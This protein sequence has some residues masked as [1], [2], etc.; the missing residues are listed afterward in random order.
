MNTPLARFD[1]GYD[2]RN[3]RTSET[4]TSGG[5]PEVRSFGYDAADRLTG[6]NEVG[7]GA[8][9]YG[10]APDGTRL[11]ERTVTGD[12]GGPL[13][14]GGCEG[15]DGFTSSSRITYQHDTSGELLGASDAVTGESWSYLT[16]PVG[17]LRSQTRGGVSRSYRWDAAGR[18]ASASVTTMVAG[19]GGTSDTFTYGYDHAGRRVSKTWPSGRVS[20][21]WGPDGVVEEQAGGTAGMVYE[22]VGALALGAGGERIMHDGLGSV[23]GRVGAGVTSYR[24]DVSGAYRGAAPGYGE[25]SLRYAGQHWDAEAGLSYA[26]QRWY[27]PGTGR[28]LS[29]DPVF[30]HQELPTSLH[31][32]IYANGNA[33]TL[34]DSDGRAAT[35][36]FAVGGFFWGFEQMVQGMAVD[37]YRGRYRSSGAYL[38]VWGQNII[39][40]TELG[41]SID[42]TA[43][44]GG[45][46]L[47]VSGALGWAGT[48]A[49]T[50]H[51]RAKDWSTFRGNQGWGLLKGAV[52]GPIFHKVAK[53]LPWVGRL[54]RRVPGAQA[55]EQRLGNALEAGAA[56]VKPAVQAIGRAGEGLYEQMEMDALFGA[57]NPLRAVSAPRPQAL[58]EDPVGAFDS[59]GS[60]KRSSSPDPYAGIKAASQ[61]L[62]STGIPR[63]QRVQWLQSFE[64]ETVRLRAAGASEYGMRYFDNAN[65]YPRGRFLFE[66]FPASRQSL[67]LSPRWNQMS[68]IAQWRIRP[69]ATV[70]E[71]RASSQGIGLEGGQLQKLVVNPPQDLL[72]P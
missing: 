39:G 63:N 37:V 23:V 56:K 12:F 21:L 38:S 41:L 45:L 10:L 31:P 66:T 15:E 6:A 4:Y 30:G 35:E 52:A 69:G 3:N 24:L 59:V 40:G 49:L 25:P 44:T 42:A 54:L 70:I 34:S 62:R 13:G 71:G 9:L 53:A 19:T 68:G 50:L 58:P 48:E 29:Q 16:D 18:M 33:A 65:A 67:A 5:P 51:G 17:Q 14:P 60:V 55:L 1:Y 64:A 2:E 7:R 11:C 36:I 47:P 22:R 26:E 57:P 46:A 61:Y 20:W 8:V 72:L 28:F 27:D 32:F 43:L